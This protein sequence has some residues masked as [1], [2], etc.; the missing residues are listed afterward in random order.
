LQESPIRNKKEIGRGEIKNEKYNIKEKQE[1][2]ERKSG[3][4]NNGKQKRM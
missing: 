3:R 4:K 2:E 1:K